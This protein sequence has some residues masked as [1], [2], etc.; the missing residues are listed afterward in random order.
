MNFLLNPLPTSIQP[1][2]NYFPESEAI[3]QWDLKLRPHLSSGKPIITRTNMS[4]LTWP[5]RLLMN[6]LFLIPSLSTP[7]I[8]EVQYFCISFA[9]HLY[10]I[11]PREALGNSSWARLFQPTRRSTVSTVRKTF[12]CGAR[13]QG[14]DPP[15]CFSLLFYFAHAQCALFYPDVIIS[16]VPHEFWCLNL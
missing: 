7:N 11:G 12:T 15:F 9:F 3:M 5:A 14:F 13:G 16:L 4:D 8:W 1:H 2:L 6:I 10:K